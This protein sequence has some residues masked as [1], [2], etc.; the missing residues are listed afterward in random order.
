MQIYHMSDIGKKRTT[1]QDFAEVFVN[2][3]DATLALLADGMGGH[4]AGDVAS[5]KTVKILGEMWSNTDFSTP[6]EVE[7]W[8]EKNIQA[9]NERIYNEGQENEEYFGMG[10]TLI[11][12]AIFYG[13]FVLAHVGDS[14]AYAIRAGE[15]VQITED[16]SLVNELVKRGELTEV[17]AIDHPRKNILTR[18]IG[19]PGVVQVDV[20]NQRI[21]AN[22]TLLLASDGLTNMVDDQHIL[23][24]LSKKQSVK[25]TTEELLNTANA[26]GGLDNITVLLIR[27]NKEGEND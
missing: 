27:F 9:I 7:K 18:T 21:E 8:M 3:A 23:S 19:M 13:S 2:K 22:D 11:A 26:N 5:K 17:E 25:E 14:R 1:N 15:M 6:H 24:I 10:T 4:R 12:V 16:H 20:T